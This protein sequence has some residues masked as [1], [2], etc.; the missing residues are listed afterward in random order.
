MGQ[1]LEQAKH[2]LRRQFAAA[3]NRLTAADVARLSLAICAR[4]LALPVFRAALHVVLYRA[5]GNEVD[6]SKLA[7][8][9]VDL[10]KRVHYPAEDLDRFEFASPQNLSF[11]SQTDDSSLLSPET[12]D[13]CFLVPGLGFDR[14]G[15]RLGRGSGWYDRALARHPRGMRV[16]LAYEFQLVPSLPEASWDV[17]M[18]TVVTEARVL[19]GVAQCIGQ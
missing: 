19:D 15:V 16:G 1:N 2:L 8:T 11:A 5:I 17:R 13:V 14:R 6:P 18:N 4:V 3:R 9:A 7:A 10:G 12:R